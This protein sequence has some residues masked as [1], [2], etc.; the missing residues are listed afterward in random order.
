[1]NDRRSLSTGPCAGRLAN[2]ML[3]NRGLPLAFAEST[4]PLALRRPRAQ[5]SSLPWASEISSL[6][7]SGCRDKRLG[8]HPYKQF[9]FQLLTHDLGPRKCGLQELRLVV[10]EIS[11]GWGPILN[12][13]PGLA[14]PRP[15]LQLYC[16]C[17]AK[18]IL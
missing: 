6:G 8:S 4:P 13:T 9:P 16:A 11:F 17:P 5:S 18:Q 2:R 7:E 14:V 1:M 3:L 10:G 12:G 15:H